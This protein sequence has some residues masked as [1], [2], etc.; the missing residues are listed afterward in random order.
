[1]KNIIIFKKK[2]YYKFKELIFKCLF[3]SKEDLYIF[4]ARSQRID[5]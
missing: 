2:K 4:I 1:M 3:I 5:S